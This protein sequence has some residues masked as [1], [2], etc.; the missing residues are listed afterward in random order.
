MANLKQK[1]LH[2][3][4]HENQLEIALD[5]LSKSQENLLNNYSNPAI[6]Q[7]D[8]NKILK[9]FTDLQNIRNLLHRYNK[10]NENNVLVIT[11]MF[12]TLKIVKILAIYA[13]PWMGK[14]SI[15]MMKFPKD[16]IQIA[17]VLLKLSKKQIQMIIPKLIQKKMIVQLKYHLKAQILKLHP[18]KQHLKLHN[19][20]KNGYHL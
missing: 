5:D 10:L 2:A 6:K 20:I 13:N 14:N 8:K 4:K 7:K 1:V 12:G 19:K 11:N 15:F 18:H 9:K 3:L 16:L 17:N